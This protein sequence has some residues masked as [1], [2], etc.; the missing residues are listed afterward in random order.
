[1]YHWPWNTLLKHHFFCRVCLSLS[2]FCLQCW[3]SVVNHWHEKRGDHI[4]HWSSL[5][6][7]AFTS[8]VCCRFLPPSCF[9]NV[10]SYLNVIKL[11]HKCIIILCKCGCYEYWC[12]RVSHSQTDHYLNYV[13]YLWCHNVL[14]FNIHIINKY[15]KPIFDMF[16]LI[17]C[18]SKTVVWWN[19]YDLIRI[20]TC[21]HLK[22]TCCNLIAN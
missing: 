1:M 20:E 7:K 14:L 3:W 21:V 17:T 16:K 12:T 19:L 10:F 22:S 2:L 6:S 13:W 18:L 9:F 11:H 15:S 5:T 8:K 4:W